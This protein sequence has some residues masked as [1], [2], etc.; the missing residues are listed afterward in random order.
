MAC[1]KGALSGHKISGVRFVLQDG[2]C[3]YFYFKLS[4][5]SRKYPDKFSF[6]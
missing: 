2:K 4:V 5:K 3:I 6:L 1:E